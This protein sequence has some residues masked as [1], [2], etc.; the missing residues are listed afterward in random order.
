MTPE[1]QARLS[2]QL[3]AIPIPDYSGLDPAT[4]GAVG[5]PA[6]S[7]DQVSD[8]TPDA[9]DPS[10]SQV[11][12]ADGRTETRPTSE[13][14][15]LPRVPP[16]PPPAPTGPGVDPGF[17]LT[18]AQTAATS[19]SPETAMTSGVAGG[20]PTPTPEELDPLQP[21]GTART[22]TATAQPPGPAPLVAPGGVPGVPGA[23][24]TTAT[25]GA[26]TNQTVQDP[27]QVANQYA[28]A[29]NQ[30]AN[31]LD[32]SAQGEQNAKAAENASLL[33]SNEARQKQLFD[34]AEKARIHTEEARAAVKAI[35]DTPIE[36]DFMKGQPGRQVGAW[37]AL[38]LSGFLQGATRGANP[39][40]G[41]MMSALQH[42]Q[43]RFI[44]NQREDRNSKFNQRLKL[45]D[46]AKATE[47]SIR[48]QL[49]GIIQQHAELQARKLGLAEL[50]PAI[51]TVG[52][53]MRVEGAKHQSDLGMFV[54]RKTEE[55]FAETQKASAAAAPAELRQLGVDPK[56]HERAMS[57]Q[58]GALGTKV[59]TADQMASDLAKLNAIVSKNGGQLQG[60]TVASWSKLGLASFLA[61]NGNENAS[62]QV[63]AQ[64]ILD[65]FMLAAKQGG[66]VKLFDSEKE[67]AAF[68]KTL[69]TGTTQ[70]TMHALQDLTRRAQ[71]NALGTASAYA[72]ANP[73]GYV[74]Y[75]RKTLGSA[76][77]APASAGG[78]PGFQERVIIPGSGDAG[79]GPAP[80]SPLAPSPS[81]SAPGTPT[82]NNE[83]P[84]RL[85][86]LQT[87][88]DEASRAGLKGDAIARIV[89]FESGGRA[90][91]KNP[92]GATGLIQWMPN[93]FQGMTKPPGYENVR[94]SDLPD[95]TAE[96]QVPL[97]IQYFKEKFAAAGVD[98]S[99]LDVGDYYLAVAAPAAIG[100]PDSTV[101]YPKGS[102]AWTQNA[103]WRPA[104]GGDITAGSI[105]ARA[106]S[107]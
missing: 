101:V 83:D 65:R 7:P 20:V 69:N 31:A 13:A 9:I 103:A 16:P 99:K 86:T 18:P 1:E 96:E 66:N 82:A 19:A 71:R 15:A 63:Q 6:A 47:A 78:S 21:A 67:A 106:R 4:A 105:R 94:H 79:G 36:E 64:Q 12:F 100:K 74:D 73:Q 34:D 60:Q 81:A 33:A 72:P 87:I 77:A 84:V 93:V 107:F 49:P 98:P 56:A 8:V 90:D 53:Q 57:D 104:D 75:V 35:E 50:P 88:S 5:G 45:L 28:G 22:L 17:Q 38:A 11:T 76:G 92:S 41:Q 48:M 54:Q 95:L 97:A 55:R 61:R 40:L 46:D 59:Q 42:A 14:N 29:V 85:K 52:A 39:A 30:T 58:H 51:S 70:E 10:W 3:S 27:T 43:D 44:Q 80:S 89:R 91:A 32:E 25:V 68:E 23:E 2:G 37:V 62:E 102:A 24:S 26:T